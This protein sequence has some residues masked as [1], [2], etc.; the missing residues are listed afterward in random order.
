[1]SIPIVD[2][3]VN[4]LV[5]VCLSIIFG[6]SWVSQS[7]NNLSLY[8]II[9]TLFIYSF[10]SQPRIIIN[11]KPLRI[12]FVFLLWSGLTTVASNNMDASLKELKLLGGIFMLSF[13]FVVFAKQNSSYV[14][15]IYIG[16]IITFLVNVLNGF[17]LGLL[18]SKNERFSSELINANEFGYYGFFAI[19]ASFFLWK[20]VLQDK[21]GNYK[22]LF[23]SFIAISLLS[24]TANFYAASRAGII[25]SLGT[26]FILLN[27]NY[28]YPFSR[29]KIFRISILIVLIYTVMGVVSNLYFDSVLEQRINNKNIY[30]ES[31]F[32]LIKLA[33]NTGLDNLFFGVGPGNFLY[34]TPTL[35]FSHSTF[36]EIFAN[37][38]LIG[39]IIYLSLFFYAFKKV[40]I[41]KKQ[42]KKTG[43]VFLFIIT[44]YLIYNLF[45]VFHTS[46]FLG[47]FLF[48]IIASID[49]LIINKQNIKI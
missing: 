12:L 41:L 25:I 18:N 31:R 13:I 10:L 5:L 4:I 35:H 15:Y 40:I 20:N 9:P 37:N 29:K 39:L 44:F 16:Y 22:I 1:M 32:D 49:M 45:Y 36:F 21:A 2:K 3:K 7:L 48:L 47:S 6:F 43:I 19:V 26:S 28:F 17:S 8:F 30:E 42:N 46:L 33:F 38:G 24:V 11:Y 14:K 34:F 23:F 27:I